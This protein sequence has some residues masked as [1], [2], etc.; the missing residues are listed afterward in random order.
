MPGSDYTEIKV[1]GDIFPL[2][3]NRDVMTLLAELLSNQHALFA[4]VS[5]DWKNA[6]GELPK[7]T[8]ALTADTTI[9][10]LQWSLDAGLSKGGVC[11]RVAECS[12]RDVLQCAV[13]NGCMLT[14]VAWV[15]AAD[16]GD[17]EMIEWRLDRPP[18]CWWFV[19]CTAAAATGK[20][21][22]LKWA[23]GLGCPWDEHV[24]SETSGL[25]RH[26]MLQ[27]ARS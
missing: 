18:Y 16:G 2:N 8:Q 1:T 20:L 15:T 24:C 22:M 27:W 11:V 25:G 14:S 3:A 6:W 9:S 4:E 12:S 10:Q 21:D 7:I 23:R 17:Q 19:L 26:Y 13:S 5:I